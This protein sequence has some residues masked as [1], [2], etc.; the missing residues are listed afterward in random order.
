VFNGCETL[1]EHIIYERN[2][3]KIITTFIYTKDDPITIREYGQYT[4]HNTIKE[5]WAG[6]CI[7]ERYNTEYRESLSL[8]SDP[9]AFMDETGSTE[10]KLPGQSQSAQYMY[11]IPS[12]MLPSQDNPFVT[13]LELLF[14]NYY[15]TLSAIKAQLCNYNGTCSAIK[16]TPI[17]Y[18]GQIS[19]GNMTDTWKLKNTDIKNHNLQIHL[20][21]TNNTLQNRTFTYNNLTLNLYWQDDQTIGLTGFTL[22][23]IHSRIY[24][25]YFDHD[26]NTNIDLNLKT[27]EIN[28]KILGNTLKETKYRQINNW[29]TNKRTTNQIPI[30]NTLIFDYN[31]T[32]QYQVTIRQMLK[33]T[34][35]RIKND[36]K[37]GKLKKLR[38]FSMLYL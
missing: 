8:L 15:T 37:Q 23:N 35:K 30:P 10:L 26:N 11:S 17:Q 22:N 31:P 2:W 36:L 29:L 4:P 9:S 18:I 34:K 1:G 25:I 16:T 6:L 14:N 7:N 28:F 13:G 21:F 32:P 38:H 5:L 19:L 12:I 20:T 24:Q 33:N 3:E 27:L